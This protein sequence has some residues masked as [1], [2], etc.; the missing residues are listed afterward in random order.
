[1]G[2]D[3]SSSGG[4]TLN[5]A[6]ELRLKT[7]PNHTT[8]V[9]TQNGLTVKSIFTRVKARNGDGDGNPMIFALKQAKGFNINRHNLGWFRPCFYRILNEVL[10]AE[11]SP[12]V[13][14]LPSNSPVAKTFASIVARETDGI[15]VQDYFKKRTNKDNISSI[16]LENVKEKDRNLVNR[17]LSDLRKGPPMATISLKDFKTQIRPYFDPIAINPH[18]NGPDVNDNVILID[19][20]YST[21]RT[22]DSAVSILSAAGI[23][24]NKAF[25][26]LSG[27]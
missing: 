7:H 12:T 21:G 24:C 5:K 22:L 17:K 20:L 27:V 3:I 13:L 25:C 10:A 16:D 18:Y 11:Q 2:I 8:W 15:L 23:T 14:C 9:K 26:L 19:D 4:V 6:H 1:M